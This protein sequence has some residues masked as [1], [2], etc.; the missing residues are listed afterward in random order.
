M[1]VYN[2]EENTCKDWDTPSYSNFFEERHFYYDYIVY[3]KEIYF[4]TPESIYVYN[5]DGKMIR[6]WQFPISESATIILDQLYILR[7]GIIYISDLQ[8]HPIKNWNFGQWKR[9]ESYTK[10]KTNY[11][12]IK[13]YR[14]RLLC[15]DRSTFYLFTLD[16]QKLSELIRKESRGPRARVDIFVDDI[17][18]TKSKVIYIYRIVS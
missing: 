17:Y 11:V 7:R 4:R 16:G 18:I 8:G 13:E 12:E 9:D 10:S 2:L 3:K 14:T 5:F 15:I 1:R 6:T